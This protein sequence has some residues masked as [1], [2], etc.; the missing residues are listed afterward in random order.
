MGQYHILV[1]LDKRE[2]V[3]PHMLGAGLKLWEQLMTPQY[4]GALVALLAVSNG[5]GGGDLERSPLVGRWGGDRIAIVG[6]YAEDGDLAP[7]HKA[8]EIYDRHEEEWTD[9]S[10]EIAGL[11]EREMGG[12]FSGDGWRDWEGLP[13]HD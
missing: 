4:G 5:R 13:D 2:Y 8:S 7:E 10:S 6:D 3:N 9:I 1:N 11:I 12:K